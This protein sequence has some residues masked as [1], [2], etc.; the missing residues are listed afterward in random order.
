[1]SEVKPEMSGRGR[2]RGRGAGAAVGANADKKRENENL[3]IA[4][5]PPSKKSKVENNG[6]ELV[7]NVKKVFTQLNTWKMHPKYQDKVMVVPPLPGLDAQSQESV[8]RFSM[9]Q[10]GVQMEMFYVQMKPD[11]SRK[12]GDVVICK[13]DQKGSTLIDTVAFNL[14]L[15]APETITTLMDKEGGFL[16][17]SKLQSN[18]TSATTEVAA[19]KRNI[20]Q[21]K[22][23]QAASLAEYLAK[24]EDYKAK[25]TE[26]QTE[27][28]REAKLTE[29]LTNLND[30]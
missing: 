17:A 16:K 20:A 3:D 9:L 30:K 24:F 8:V 29:R 7:D 2:G 18:I 21:F 27:M 5:P 22:R 13:T 15:E 14:L 1:M 11:N 6:I 4:S 10:S 26:L 25:T 19:A 28:I 12:R 23:A